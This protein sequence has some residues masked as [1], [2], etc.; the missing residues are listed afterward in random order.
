MSEEQLEH[1]IAIL[2]SALEPLHPY[3]REQLVSQL[4]DGYCRKCLDRVWPGSQCF[5]ENDD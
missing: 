5:C 3:K 1:L 2:R 4:L